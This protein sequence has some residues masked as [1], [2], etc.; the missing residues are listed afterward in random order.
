MIFTN[1]Y[2]IS[3]KYIPSHIDTWINTYILYIHS[4]YV[5]IASQL[6]VFNFLAIATSQQLANV[7]SN[8][9]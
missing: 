9:L 2:Y 7:F 4:S 5:R 8:T 3:N 6:T 1:Y